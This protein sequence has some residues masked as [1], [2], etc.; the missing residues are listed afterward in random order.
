MEDGATSNGQTSTQVSD[1]GI[2]FVVP[3]PQVPPMDEAE[4]HPFRPPIDH[5]EQLRQQE[6]G[7]V[8]SAELQ[9]QASDGIAP[10][11]ADP[12][13]MQQQQQQQPSTDP[14]INPLKQSPTTPPEV[15]P[16]PIP[17]RDSMH[18]FPPQ[19]DE[20]AP[21]QQDLERHPSVGPLGERRR[22]MSLKER[23]SSLLER[24]HA[25]AASGAGAHG[26]SADL[27]HQ[28][29]LLEEQQQQAAVTLSRKNV[30][31]RMIARGNNDSGHIGV[32]FAPEVVEPDRHH[33]DP[34]QAPPIE[35]VATN[36]PL[37]ANSLENELSGA[38]TS[39]ERMRAQQVAQLFL[40]SVKREQ[41][42]PVKIA[43]DKIK[44]VL[45]EMA[46]LKTKH[47]AAIDT[48]EKQ[49]QFL[50][51]QM[52][53]AVAAYTRKFTAD[54][55][56]RVTALEREYKRRLE[57]LN[58]S[59]LKDLRAQIEKVKADA[60]K[61]EERSRERLKE[62]QDELEQEKRIFAAKVEQERESLRQQAER[63]HQGDAESYE[64]RIHELEEE[65]R[66]AKN[67]GLPSAA[68]PSAQAEQVE[69]LESRVQTLQEQLEKETSSKLNLQVDLQKMWTQLEAAQQRIEQ[70][71]QQQQQLEQQQQQQQA[72]K[73]PSRRSS[74]H[75]VDNAQPQPADPKALEP[76]IIP[77]DAPALEIAPNTTGA[78]APP[79][80]AAA[81]PPAAEPE[82]RPHSAFPPDEEF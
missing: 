37:N 42:I 19:N 79:P 68:S 18:A 71:E 31:S 57:N 27:V 36:P 9:H 12:A 30:A 25:S 60:A 54:Y 43:R 39:E 29:T 23:R 33:S 72:A 48:M 82:E 10:A 21:E 35:V 46:Q 56:N 11:P 65:L 4:T 52:E 75:S 49:H 45:A 58:D 47:M 67:A 61:A 78:E 53:S 38:I 62:K 24:S 80:A 16:L 76:P 73:V 1:G 34:L 69:E 26:S 5:E 50:K 14:T 8:N 41:Y 64:K 28:P 44:Q 81:A 7:R 32:S 63:L 22:S 3:Q 70:L 74:R 13:Y 2:T 15:P 20:S 6:E 40:P 51:A 55:N 17:P 59:A 66:E 77:D